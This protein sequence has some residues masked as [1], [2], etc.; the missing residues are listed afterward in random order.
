MMIKIFSS[1]ALLI[2]LGACSGNKAAQRT[3]TCFKGKL[4]VKGGCMNYTISIQE[5]NMDSSLYVEEWTDENT[6][7]QYDKVFALASKCSFPANIKEGDTFYFT[8][9]STPDRSCSVCMMYYPVPPRSLAIK[10][11]QEPCQ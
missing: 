6:G 2:T 4:E 9:D 8:I 1:L 5:G 10:V 11:Q 3:D 7:K